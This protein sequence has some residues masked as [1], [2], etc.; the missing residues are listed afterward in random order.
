MISIFHHF[1]K[2]V[3]S[4]KKTCLEKSATI[5]VSMSCPIDPI[6]SH[7]KIMQLTKE[8]LFDELERRRAKVI[9]NLSEF[10]LQ[11]PCLFGSTPTYKQASTTQRYLQ[12]FGYG[13]KVTDDEMRTPIGTVTTDTTY[14]FALEIIAI[15]LEVDSDRDTLNSSVSMLC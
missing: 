6:Y 13:T 12:L 4:H 5:Q 9:R 2:R 14:L 1:T 8:E 7:S 3:H 10:Y 11:G 15:Y